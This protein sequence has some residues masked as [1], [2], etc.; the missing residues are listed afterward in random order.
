MRIQ[1][2]IKEVYGQKFGYIPP[3]GAFRKFRIDPF[4]LGFVMS[5]GDCAF[6]GCR[7]DSVAYAWSDTELVKINLP[8]FESEKIR[9]ERLVIECARGLINRGDILSPADAERLNV[10][11]ERLDEM[12][13]EGR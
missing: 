4:R 10:A 7:A 8:D 6:F 9:F 2:A 13:W 11:V 5:L 3:G 12:A 1:D